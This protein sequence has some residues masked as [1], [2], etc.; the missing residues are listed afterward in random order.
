MLNAV[1]VLNSGQ[2]QFSYCLELKSALTMVLSAAFGSFTV[3]TLL[4]G[5]LGEGGKS[6]LMCKALKCRA[7]A[8]CAFLCLLALLRSPGWNRLEQSSGG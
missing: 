4:I 7:Y 6:T 3:H 2:C 5:L 1:T 8:R